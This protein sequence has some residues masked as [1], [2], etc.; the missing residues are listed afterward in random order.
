MKTS[1][2]ILAVIVSLAIMATIAT[3]LA[4]GAYAV[5]GLSFWGIFELAIGTQLIIPYLFENVWEKYVL[6]KQIDEYNSKPYKQY[7]IKTACQHCGNLAVLNLDLDDTEYVCGNCHK[8][9]AVHV[10]FMTAAI[11]TPVNTQVL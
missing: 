6:K 5:F 1:K 9:N 3:L 8:H 7:P 10:T 2:K 4:S 11:Q